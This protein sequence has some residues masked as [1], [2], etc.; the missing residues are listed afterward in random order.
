MNRRTLISIVAI[1]AIAIAIMLVISLETY[2]SNAGSPAARATMP[3]V[4]P[5]TAAPQ[6]PQRG[7]PPQIHY[8]LNPQGTQV[9]VP[10]H[11]VSATPFPHLN[12]PLP[13][14]AQ[15]VQAICGHQL[16]AHWDGKTLVIGGPDATP[17][18]K[19]CPTSGATPQA[20]A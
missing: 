5:T 20:T 18:T 14:A 19:P 4:T 9:A 6:I 15:M 2:A 16:S 12:D 13:P 11:P 7:S 3:S 1:L 10:D 8:V 17:V